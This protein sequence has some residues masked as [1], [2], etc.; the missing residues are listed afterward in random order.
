MDVIISTNKK[1]QHKIATCISSIDD[2]IKGQRNLIYQLKEH[3]R[4]LMQGLFPKIE[5]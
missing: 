2:I 3:K 4:G 5:E 1:E